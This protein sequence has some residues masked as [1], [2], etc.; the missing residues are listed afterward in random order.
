MFRGWNIR[1]VDGEDKYHVN[2]N[3]AVKAPGGIEVDIV[4]EYAYVTAARD[5]FVEAACSVCRTPSTR[6]IEALEKAHA[7]YKEALE[8]ERAG[9]G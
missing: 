7:A 8:N 9:R 4:T 1:V 3:L 2:A 5:A 6:Q